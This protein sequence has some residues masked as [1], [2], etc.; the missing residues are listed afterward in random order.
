MHYLLVAFDVSLAMKLLL[1]PVGPSDK[2]IKWIPLIAGFIP[3]KQHVCVLVC[4][5]GKDYSPTIRAAF[6][7]SYYARLFTNMCKLQSNVVQTVSLEVISFFDP[8]KDFYDKLDN[9][10]FLFMAGFTTDVRHVEAIFRRDD[11]SMTLKRMRVANKV[12]TNEMAMWAVCGSAVACGTSWDIQGSGRVLPNSLYQ[13]LEVLA[14]GRI[15]YD[16]CSGPQGITVT[17]NLREWHVSSGTGLIIVTNHG[18]QHGESFV[19]VKNHRV[20]SHAQC[21]TITRKMM[22]QLER[23]SSMVVRYRS[24]Q[25]HNSRCWCLFWG[26]GKVQWV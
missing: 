19:C 26:T 4:N 3:N 11:E 8:D 1:T 21:V 12:V 23:L 10:D 5:D 24:E 14:D 22:R 6:D 9:C 16:A 25:A 17:N 13:M 18:L 2:V 15:C 7:R 20:A